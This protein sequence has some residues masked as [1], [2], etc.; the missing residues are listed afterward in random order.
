MVQVRVEGE[1]QAEDVWVPQVEADRKHIA[2]IHEVRV[3]DVWITSAILK[4]EFCLPK[5]HVRDMS[6][7]K[8]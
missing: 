8:I 3:P 7:V 4:N 2:R 5:S 1:D 6:P